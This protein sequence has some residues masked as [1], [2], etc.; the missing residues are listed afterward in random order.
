ML[1]QTHDD[2]LRYE[3]VTASTILTQL[4]TTDLQCSY[5]LYTSLRGQQSQHVALYH[6][7]KGTSL[8][9]WDVDCDTFSFFSCRPP[10]LT[11]LVRTML[12]LA[13]KLDVLMTVLMI[14]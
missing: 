13:E 9:Q 11:S 6:R 8:R 2:R 1:I 7:G 14:V 3:Q 4:R 5:M 10:S 12:L